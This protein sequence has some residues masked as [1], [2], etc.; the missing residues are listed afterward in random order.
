VLVRA[1]VAEQRMLH[2][3]VEPLFKFGKEDFAPLL[4]ETVRSQLD[5]KIIST[6][7]AMIE[8]VQGHRIHDDGPKLFH[9]IQG[10]SRT[11]IKG[12]VQVAHKVIE[13]DQLHGAG[14]LGGEQRVSEAEQRVHRISRRFLPIYMACKRYFPDASRATIMDTKK[15]FGCI[16]VSDQNAPPLQMKQVKQV[17][18]VK[19][20]K[21]TVNNVLKGKHS[22]QTNARQLIPMEVPSAILL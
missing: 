16:H 9:Q 17:K 8:H 5:D 10:Q 4:L 11:P 14:N 20:M 19:Q 2:F 6:E 3:F 18:Q 21:Q 22:H 12:A 1:F 15:L 7:H 13:A